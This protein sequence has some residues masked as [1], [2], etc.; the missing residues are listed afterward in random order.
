MNPSKIGELKLNE[1]GDFV[2]GILNPLLSFFGFCALLYTIHIQRKQIND[3][4]KDR[5]K[6]Q[7]ESTFFSLLAVHNQILQNFDRAKIH[8]HW[9]QILSGETPLNHAK[10]MLALNSHLYGHYFRIL[11]QLL[12]FIAINSPDS[13]IGLIFDSEKIKNCK[14][15]LNE[16]MYSNIV[17]ALLTDEIMQLLAVNCYCENG[18]NDSYWKYKLLIERYA[19]FE[20][21]PFKFC[22][23]GYDDDAI[24][25]EIRNFYDKRAFGL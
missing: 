2:G 1:F 4:K 6:Q 15:S 17:R 12:K 7:F 13:Q 22:T 10:S 19:L 23:K 20:H 25:S 16:K 3:D 18:K 24:F 5:K 9:T 14:I 8:E 21:A 11:Y